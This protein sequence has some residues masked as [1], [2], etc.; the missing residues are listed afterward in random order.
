MRK[1]LLAVI[2]TLGLTATADLAAA[3]Q[4]Q[5]PENKDKNAVEKTADKAKEA[6]QE[7]TD[8]AGDVKD[9]SVKGV[10]KTGQK[11]KEVA[12]E[13]GDK[14]EDVKDK[15]VDTTK[16][17]VNEVG[18]K[19]EDVKDKTATGVKVGTKGA[20]AIGSKTVDAAG[21]VWS[22]G[23]AVAVVTGTLDWPE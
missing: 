3:Q 9:K 14:A 6:G 12:G 4:N 22:G 15:T 5:T 8:K 19:A 23:R 11:T 20:K 18:D 13:A 2:C 16:K 17:G 21:D 7:V 10:K 1:F